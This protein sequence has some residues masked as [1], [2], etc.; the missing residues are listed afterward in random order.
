[1]NAQFQHF[2][3]MPL[4][5]YCRNALIQFLRRVNWNVREIAVKVMRSV[6]GNFWMTFWAT[7]MLAAWDLFCHSYREVCYIHWRFITL[8]CSI[9]WSHDTL[10]VT[11]LTTPG[12]SLR[13][14]QNIY[15]VRQKSTESILFI[16]S[17]FLFSFFARRV[18]QKKKLLTRYLCTQQRLLSLTF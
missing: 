7:I 16:R 15:Q 8:F 11:D 10:S 3:S 5:L 4:L 14:R 18:W 17:I 6:S 13:T 1:M 2:S 12:C 9:S